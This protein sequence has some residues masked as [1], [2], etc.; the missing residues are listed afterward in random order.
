MSQAVVGLLGRG[1]I[2]AALVVLESRREKALVCQKTG[3]NVWVQDLSWFNPAMIPANAH[4]Q[5]VN[6]PNAMKGAVKDINSALCLV[7]VELRKTAC[8][9]HDLLIDSSAGTLDHVAGQRLRGLYVVPPVVLEHRRE[10]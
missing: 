7:L 5:S 8:L 10:R 9:T 3:S 2:A 1:L 6:G 4:G